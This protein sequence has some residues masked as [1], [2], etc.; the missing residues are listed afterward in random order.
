M[1]IVANNILLLLKPDSAGKRAF[2]AH[3]LL[4]SELD[5]ARAH[6]Q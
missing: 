6:A 2:S 1:R 5:S 4:V 3:N